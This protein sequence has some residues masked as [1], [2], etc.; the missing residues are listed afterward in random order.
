MKRIFHILFFVCT[1]QAFAQQV[2]MY[3]HYFFNQFV[4]NP[5][6]AGTGDNIQAMLLS[7]SQWTGFSNAPQLN[8]FTLDG[9]IKAKKAG[10][11]LMLISDKRGLNQRTGGN[12]AYSYRI[13]F[14]EETH[15]L[16]GLSMGLINQTFDFS[17]AVS[18]NYTDPTLFT[19][20]Q[21]KITFDGSGGLA[22]LWKGLTV[23]ASALQALGNKVNYVDNTGTRTF[24]QQVRHYLF[25]AKYRFYLS[26]DKGISLSPMALVRVVPGTPLQYEGNLT[27]DWYNK[28][29]AGATY[30]SD[31][32]VAVN[33]GVYLHKK[34]AIGY[35]YEF[36]TSSIGK[37]AGVSHEIMVSFKFGNGKKEATADSMK[38][39][40][41]RQLVKDS[42]YQQKIDSLQ[43]QLS[44]SSGNVQ[45][46]K[47]KVKEQSRLQKQ[48][49][50]QVQNLEKNI[51]DLSAKLT[52]NQN[53]M[54]SG[55][56]N[57]SKITSPENVPTNSG[58]TNAVLN[59]GVGNINQ[60]STANQNSSALDKLSSKS[61]EDGVPIASDPVAGYKNESNM[62][63]K[64]AYYVVVGTFYYRDFAE[65][66]MKRFKTRGYAQSGL[67]FSEAKLYNYVFAGMYLSKQEAIRKTQAVQA[68][69]NKDAWILQL[70]K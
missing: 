24:Y 19:S 30:K 35:S 18:E 59:P 14:N 56:N 43:G 21:Q 55:N 47:E 42:V 22:F 67:V 49:Q 20:A 66:E 61:V 48:T 27:L 53:T 29:W 32:A 31:Y 52:E 60:P 9:P 23:G 15:I 28:L 41:Q 70:T 44:E 33:A 3:N 46:L 50:E 40:R 68:A 39:E 13:S 63:A 64:A 34:L 26:E 62:Q 11:G 17:K 54:M 45:Q 5:A 16:F 25:S 65:A 4:Y 37:Y 10:L 38:A 57:T 2:G 69:G 36:I 6:F 51:Q 58:N 7:R 8:I 12:L 1:A